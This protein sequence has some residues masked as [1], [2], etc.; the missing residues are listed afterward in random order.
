[1]VVCLGGFVL[2]LFGFACLC[3]VFVVG[4][5]FG[6]YICWCACCWCSVGI[7]LLSAGLSIGVGW[8]YCY[9]GCLFG[10]RVVVSVLV[11]VAGA[12]A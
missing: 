9:Y 7:S 3:V 6:W 12:F 5:W 11:L 2:W 4:D 10:C 8:L 1:M